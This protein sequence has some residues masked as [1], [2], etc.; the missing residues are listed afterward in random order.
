LSTDSGLLS[1]LS[2]LE[3]FQAG[4]RLTSSLAGVD[5]GIQ[6][7][8]GFLPSPV[9]VITPGLPPT[10]AMD[11][12]RYHQAGIDCAAVVAGFNLRAE[13]AANITADLAGDEPGVYNPALAFSAGFDR[14]LFAGLSLNL[15]YAGNYRLKDGGVTSPLDVEYGKDAFSSTV[16]AVLMQS[17]LKDRLSWKLTGLYELGEEDWLVLPSL[18]YALGDASLEV[19]MGIFGG[20]AAG[21]LG[22]FADNSWIKVAAIYS[23]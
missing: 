8:Y 13:A 23:F 20:A 6:Y 11:Y 21:Q 17:L 9:V 18:S 5:L 14:E 12:N 15:Q 4:L 22:Q 3:S 2:R 16:T 10:A 19:S 7:Y 1:R